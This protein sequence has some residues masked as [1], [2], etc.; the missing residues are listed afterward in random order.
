MSVRCNTSV[1]NK[2]YFLVT[3]WEESRRYT[4]GE[5]VNCDATPVIRFFFSFFKEGSAGLVGGG[6]YFLKPSTDGWNL[7]LF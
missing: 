5:L 1:R 6:N 4:T 3:V 2:Q 7:G